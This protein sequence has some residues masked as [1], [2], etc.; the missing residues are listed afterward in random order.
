M[1]KH[2]LLIATLLVAAAVSVA[3]VSCKKEDTKALSANNAKEAFDPRQIEDMNAYLKDFRQKMQTA[4]RNEKETLSLKE[5]AW[6][7]ASLANF[8]FANANVECDDIRFD[9]LYAQVNTTNG[10]VNLSDLAL[11][12]AN[13]CTSI[14]EFYNNLLL[15]NKHFRF[16]NAF[17]SE[18]GEIILSLMTT[19]SSGSKYLS[20]NTWYF[21]DE[22]AANDSCYKYFNDNLY[23]PA[24]TVGKTKLQAALNLF[25]S[26]LTT[27]NSSHNSIYYTPTSDTTFY[28][29]NNIDP[30]GSPNYMNSR[31]FA[32]DTELNMDIKPCICYLFDSALGKGYETCPS[33]ECV[34]SW[35]IDYCIEEPYECYHERFW[36]EHYK[37][38]VSYGLKHE[39]GTQPGQEG[40]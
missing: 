10:S 17:V 13:I 4:S 5:A 14:K 1:K 35:G 29:R 16:I 24:S 3:V 30:Y 22:W 8:E 33:G 39:I 18:N 7:I 34:V 19:F 36:K 23:Y 11:A 21:E 32:N 40:D 28:Y 20:D 26:H 37:L 31:L 25:E 12:Y 27:N 38:I 2:N 15:D 6:H 9:T